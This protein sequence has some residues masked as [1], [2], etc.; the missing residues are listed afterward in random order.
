MTTGPHITSDRREAI[1]SRGR[2]H[3]LWDL[4]FP[5]I[6]KIWGHAHN[7]YAT[8][9]IF[10]LA[11]AAIAVLGT[12]GFAELAGNVRSGATQTFDDAILRW[13]GAHHSP[14]IDPIVLELTFL[15]TGTVV[16]MVVVVSGA[17]LWFTN[18]RWSATLLFVATAG[19]ILLNNVLKTGF[20]RPRPQVFPWG[21]HAVSWSFPSGHAMS[22]AAVYGTVAYLLARLQRRHTSRI[23]TM[24]L[25]MMVITLIAMTRLYLG[26]HYPSDVLAGLIIGLAWAAFCMA[27]LEAI[28]MY[29]RARAPQAL[30]HERPASEEIDSTSA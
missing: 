9:G 28:Q 27:T 12:W 24:L 30:A 29:G 19:G 4:I 6:R 7:L 21:T 10:L 26:V 16:F 5:V 13:F 17:F 22:A 23:V 3:V 2:A 1:G 20:V 8:F 18:H 25:A 15:G 14:K 11:G